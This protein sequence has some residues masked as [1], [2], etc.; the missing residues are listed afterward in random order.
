MV[1]FDGSFKRLYNLYILPLGL[2]FYAPL[3]GV[4]PS[5]DVFILSCWLINTWPA[6]IDVQ[7]I[8][9]LTDLFSYSFLYLVQGYAE[10]LR[11]TDN[12]S[13]LVTNDFSNDQ[14]NGFL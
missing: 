9:S 14:N 12:D 7:K 13:L 4:L 3:T 10:N 1:R 8:Y 11:L 6:G 2:E 5:S